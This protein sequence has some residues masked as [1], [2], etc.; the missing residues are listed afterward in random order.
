[1]GRIDAY[2]ALIAVG[3]TPPPPPPPPPT[4]APPSTRKPTRPKMATRVQR[5]VLRKHRFLWV[6]V[7]TGRVAA[8]LKSIKANSCTVSIRSDTEVWLSANHRNQAVS[9]SA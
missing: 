6:N 1:G 3:A 2:R 4:P 7:Q 9:V 8:T 5:G